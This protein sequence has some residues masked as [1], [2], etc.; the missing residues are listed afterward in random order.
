MAH[1]DQ[2]TPERVG[3]TMRLRVIGCGDAFGSGGRANTCF[4]VECGKTVAALDFG[5]TSLVELKRAGLDHDQLDVVILSH[6]HGDHFGGL[7]FLLLDAQFERK[8][9]RPLTIVG[10]V[11]TRERIHAALEVFFPGSSQVAWSFALSFVDLPC[12]EPY[13]FADLAIESVE[14]IHPSGAPATGLRVRCGDKLLAFSGDTAW[15]DA[16][17]DIAKGADLFIVECFMPDGDPYGHGALETL[18]AHRNQFQTDH[19]MLTHMSP[20]MLGRMD[21]A[22]ARGFLVAHDGLVHEV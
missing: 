15:T 20:A 16:L 12:R 7:P 3:L 11:G 1:G 5:A 13:P 10:P 4:W 22:R 14:V 18:D 21:E 17:F 8:R 9:E 6:L 2:A 19:I